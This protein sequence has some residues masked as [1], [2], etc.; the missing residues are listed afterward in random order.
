M[1][2]EELE[3]LT[4]TISPVEAPMTRGQKFQ[5]HVERGVADRM[6]RLPDSCDTLSVLV[7]V[8]SL[9]QRYEILRTSIEI[10]DGEF[11]QRVHGSGAPVV[12][13]DVASG[14]EVA[15][16]AS[17]LTAE[18]T[19]SAVR[20]VGQILARFHLLRK[21]GGLWLLVLA[22]STAIDRVFNDVLDRAITAI[23]GAPLESAPPTGL[24]PTQV[25]L[26]E[27]APAGREERRQARAHLRQ[28]FSSVTPVR[29]RHGSVTDAGGRYYRCTL[30]LTRADEVFAHLVEATGRLPAAVVL[31][32][33]GALMCWRDSVPSCAVNVSM[34]N[35]H[36]RDLRAA[37]CGTAQRAP[38]SLPISE[39]SLDEAVAAAQAAYLAGYPFAGRYDALDLIEERTSAE[40]RR[41]LNLSPELAYNFNP[42]PQGWTALLDSTGTSKTL[43]SASAATVESRGTHEDSYEYTASLSVRWSDVHTAQ[44]SV[45]GDASAVDPGQCA[46]LLRG[47]EAGLRHLAR[48]DG[49]IGTAEIAESVGL[50][51]VVGMPGRTDTRVPR[52]TE[53]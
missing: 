20:R 39:G 38:V 12:V 13:V 34:E 6:R 10:V 31:G 23:L 24:Q 49:D 16:A 44:L 50:D 35:R 43:S 26:Q 18:F 41:N 2:R 14:V 28:Y 9:Q 37:L 17:A 52:T 22:D 1:S 7:L 48:G 15:E 8:E 21:D 47:I 42:P 19:V 51:R 46:A 4:E 27:D 30:T 33:F 11:R 29:R 45:H 3:T 53:G 40:A 25:A 5:W 32:V 36:T